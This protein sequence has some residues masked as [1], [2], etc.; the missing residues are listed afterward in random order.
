[1]IKKYC[2]LAFVTFL[3]G[4]LIANQPPQKSITGN[5]SGYRKVCQE[6]ALDD[7][8]FEKFRS[9]P[10]YFHAV[11]CGQQG[12]LADYLKK[13]ATKKTLSL[14]PK[15]RKL[16]SYGQ[17]SRYPLP[18]FGAFSGTA[19]KYVLVADHIHRLFKLPENYSVAEIGAG[20]G[21]QAYMLSVLSPFSKYYI[22]DLPEVEMLIEKMMSKLNV[23]NVNCLDAYAQLPVDA[24]D[25]FIS[26]YAFSECDRI[27]QLDY[28]NRV[29][30]KSKRG[31]MLFN[32]ISSFDHLS[33]TEFIELL[34]EHGI[35]PK[36]HA[37][38]VFSYTN[39]VLITWDR[40]RQ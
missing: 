25:L 8:V 11:E 37:E 36:I 22:Y 6:A 18:R 15:F 31:Y 17:P 19:L 14:I 27:T 30:I 9:I 13:H 1:M 16:D 2:I 35:N 7:A 29:I 21:G 38:P 40:T 39:N 20:F 4:S 28:F 33:V 3:G 34:Q 32:S 26:N 10:S 23:S 12:E 24:V 5:S